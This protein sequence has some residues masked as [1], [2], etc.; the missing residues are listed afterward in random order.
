[1]T[2]MFFCLHGTE[3]THSTSAINFRVG[4]HDFFPGAGLWKA[5]SEVVIGVTGKIHDDSNWISRCVKTKEAQDVLV[6][7]AAINPLEAIVFVV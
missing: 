7:I 5:Q 6:G 3:V 1:M 2:V 4:V